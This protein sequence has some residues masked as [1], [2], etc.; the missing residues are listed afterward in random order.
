MGSEM[1][2]RDRIVGAQKALQMVTSGQHVPAKQCLEMGLVDELANE[3]NLLA[4]AIK[5]ATTIVE[6]KR[7][8]VKVRDNEE[9][10][11]ADKG[12]DTLFTDFRK[13]IARRTRGF[14]APEYNIQCI[15]A[16]V[17]KSFEEGLKVERD[18]FTKLVTGT[19]SAAQRYCLLYT[20]P[21]PRDL[22]TSRM[23]SSA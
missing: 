6:E 3:E 12:N 10:I 8:L 15:E 11:Q 18:L 5:F 7:P 13:S 20:S 1:C 9:N 16:A 4:D 2:I 14:L 21:S 22:S 19:Q 23:P 17:N